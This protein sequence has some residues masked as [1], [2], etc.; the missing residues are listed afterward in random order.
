M[1]PQEKSSDN[2]K[3]YNIPIPIMPVEQPEDSTIEQ[4]KDSTIEETKSSADYLVET[5]ECKVCMSWKAL[6]LQ[7]LRQIINHLSEKLKHSLF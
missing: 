5:L 2:K 6:P 7:W 3:D 4:T 1:Y